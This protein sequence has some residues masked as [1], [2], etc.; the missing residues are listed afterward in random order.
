M[1]RAVKQEQGPELQTQTVPA[2]ARQQTLQVLAPAASSPRRRR[3][4]RK[5]STIQVG[6][7]C[8]TVLHVLLVLV[9]FSNCVFIVTCTGYSIERER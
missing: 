2:P 1:Q 4:E 6:R 3:K 9:V 5:G 8:Y 7:M